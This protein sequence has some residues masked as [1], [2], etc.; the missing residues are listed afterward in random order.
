ML[1]DSLYS[2]EKMD[3]ETPD[4]LFLG[5]DFEFGFTLDVA[6]TPKNAKCSRYYTREDDGLVQPWEGVCWMNPPYGREVGNWM[7]KACEEAQRGV[8]T[9]A[10]V[11]ART[12]TRWWHE[13]AMKHEIR[14]LA[15]RLSFKG[16]N[17]KAPFPCAVVV[18]RPPQHAV[19]CLRS[20]KV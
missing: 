3:W 5:L 16:S 9:V 15:R 20:L 4:Y 2:S 18:I 12:D 7:R 6:A 8:T 17:N 13:T 14:F 11:P 19:P 1:N 10:L